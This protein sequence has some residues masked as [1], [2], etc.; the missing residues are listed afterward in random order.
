VASTK[1]IVTDHRHPVKGDPH[2]V[3]LYRQKRRELSLE[4]HLYVDT[5]QLA[6]ERAADNVSENLKPG[7]EEVKGHFQRVPEELHGSSHFPMIFNF[8][9][10]EGEHTGNGQRRREC[11]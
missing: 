6:P 11:E 10:G 9:A 3:A 4:E 2:L 1:A 5:A 7:A 8:V